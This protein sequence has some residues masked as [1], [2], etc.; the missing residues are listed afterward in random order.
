MTWFK[1]LIMRQN[2]PLLLI[3]SDMKINNEKEEGESRST[4]LRQPDL[5]L[6]VAKEILNDNNNRNSNN[7]NNHSS[8]IRRL[9]RRKVQQVR[10]GRRSNVSLPS[11]SPLSLLPLEYLLQN[12]C[13]DIQR[14]QQQETKSKFDDKRSIYGVETLTKTPSEIHYLNTQRLPHL[15]QEASS[16]TMTST[17][18]ATTT[19]EQPENNLITSTSCQLLNRQDNISTSPKIKPLKLANTSQENSNNNN[20]KSCVKGN[21]VNDNNRTTNKSRRKKRKTENNNNN[22]KMYYSAHILLTCLSTS[23]TLFLITSCLTSIDTANAAQQQQYFEV[24]PDSQYLVQ[25]GQDLRL[26]CL[27]RNRQGEC[28]WLRNGR[29]VGTIAKK[30]QFKRQP[31]DGDCSLMI[32]NVSV[33]QDDGIW[34]C[35]VTSSDVEQ[36]TLQS[37]EVHLVVLVPPERPQIKNM[38]SFFPFIIYERTRERERK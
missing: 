6:L 13:Q 23:L 33:Q 11:S 10:I 20:N 2:S 36:D 29:A 30:Y 19:L 32:R 38:V 8:S 27:I 3:D 24:Q 15:V 26:R 21:K 17:S 5:D 25:N 12:R 34:Q 37:T 7:N 16:V 4:T 22:N 28:L 9:G 18:V 1:S 14:Q 31:E 35:Q